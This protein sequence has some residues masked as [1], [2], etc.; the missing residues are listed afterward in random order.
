MLAARHRY[1]R[2]SGER[3]T[4][5]R[6]AGRVETT[7]RPIGRRP[8]SHPVIREVV[9]SIRV[10]ACD[11]DLTGFLFFDL[12][13]F[14]A[15]PKFNIAGDDSHFFA[16]GRSTLSSPGIPVARLGEVCGAGVG[17]VLPRAQLGSSFRSI[18]CEAISDA[19][20]ACLRALGFS[21]GWFD[22]MT[23]TASSM[24][25]IASGRVIGA[26][27][28]AIHASTAESRSGCKRTPTRV[29]LPVGAGPRRF[30][31]ITV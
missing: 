2:S 7:G 12:S 18:V 28:L 19:R 23:S 6:A 10:F 31:V 21:L 20:A 14:L 9:A 15:A 16:F 4:L 27:C 30:F 24:A 13:T 11:D 3:Q 8:E 5:A 17:R 1:R 22:T 29:P 25:R 26:V